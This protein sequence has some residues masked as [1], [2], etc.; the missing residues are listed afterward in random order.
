MGLEK[1]GLGAFFT[2]LD[3][4]F[5]PWI[6]REKKNSKLVQAFKESSLTDH[7]DVICR[8]LNQGPTMSF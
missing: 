2:K 6:F 1:V 4:Y 7:K 3:L 5:H 8:F